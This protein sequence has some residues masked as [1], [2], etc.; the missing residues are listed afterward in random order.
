MSSVIEQCTQALQRGQYTLASALACEAL[1][2]TEASAT[3]V[4]LL[5]RLAEAQV[6]LQD[7]AAAIQTWQQAYAQATIPTDKT[8]LFGQ[9][10]LIY[11]HLQDYPALL[12]LAQ[13][14]LL[15]VR[16][17]QERAA[18][19]LAAGEALF[20]LRQG[21]E[22]RQRY[23][24]PA[25]KLAGVVPRRAL[26]CGRPWAAAIWPSTLLTPRRTRFAALS[27]SC[28][29]YALTGV[30][31]ICPYCIL[32]CITRAIPRT[33]TMGLSISSTTDRTRQCRP[34]RRCSPR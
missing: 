3:R 19:L 5:E 27:S 28:S 16:S 25:L 30:P 22:A 10:C 6:G 17:D 32:S 24:E 15:H 11:E 12:R 23:L 8:R 18:C 1:A 26:V 14:Q 31:P 13:D 29:A 4:L 7:Y 2:T 34:C 9:A 20:H 33:F 21:P